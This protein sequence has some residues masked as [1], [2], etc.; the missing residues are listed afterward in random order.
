[1]RILWRCSLSASH[2]A[3]W[4]SAWTLLEWKR[5]LPFLLCYAM[6]FF[7]KGSEGV[8][9][10][11]VWSRSRSN[12]GGQSAFPVTKRVGHFNMALSHAFNTHICGHHDCFESHSSVCSKMR[13]CSTFCHMWDTDYMNPSMVPFGDMSWKYVWRWFPIF[14]ILFTL[15]FHGRSEKQNKQI[16][17]KEVTNQSKNKH[18]M[19][20]FTL[21]KILGK[22]LKMLSVFK[23]W[24]VYICCIKI[25]ESILTRHILTS[26]A[27]S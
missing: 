12:F 26:S 15:I 2:G 21:W 18:I 16:E 10:H 7:V 4:G 19:R 6:M 8:S 20:K 14:S 23:G 25:D 11:T 5:K 13:S 17:N 27:A 3:E 22:I 24:N 9:P 1:M